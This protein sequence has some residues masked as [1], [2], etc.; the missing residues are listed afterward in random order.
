MGIINP[1]VPVVG[2][3]NATEEPKIPGAINTIASEI[4]GNLDNANIK[5]G[6]NI[7]GSK[8]LNASVVTAKIGPGA[9]TPAQL[10]A[11][12][13]LSDKI[14]FIFRHATGGASSSGVQVVAS[15]SDVL[16][17]TYFAIGQIGTNTNGHSPTFV[18]GSGAATITQPTSQITNAARLYGG[19]TSPI[20][21]GALRGFG[22]HSG[23]IEVTSTATI[24]LTA[25]RTAV[26]GEI[27]GMLFMFG[28]LAA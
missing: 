15:L 24:D 1:Q 4:N 14:K 12:A 8:L 28:V 13:V 2:Q 10:A 20:S 5:T 21:D 11:L 27:S 17:G 9:I 18:L 25:N 23:M 6:A 3:P 22:M 7:N 26:S 19:A 16:P